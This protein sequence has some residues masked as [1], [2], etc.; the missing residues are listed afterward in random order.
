MTGGLP[1]MTIE[2]ASGVIP[3]IAIGQIETV[4]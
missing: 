1:R 2:T 4:G 3:N